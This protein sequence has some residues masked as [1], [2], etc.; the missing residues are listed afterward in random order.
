MCC[1]GMPNCV[2]SKVAD[3]PKSA[4]F[5]VTNSAFA[6]I[7]FASINAF[8]FRVRQRHKD[9]AAELT[10]A[11]AQADSGSS[12]L[13]DPASIGTPCDVTRWQAAIL[14]FR[15]CVLLGVFARIR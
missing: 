10:P 15:A 12:G 13:P 9:I 4:T 11:V 6:R 1:D 5:T 8:V 2:G 3:R 7:A 14:G